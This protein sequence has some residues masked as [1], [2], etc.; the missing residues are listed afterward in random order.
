MYAYNHMVLA[1]GS[2]FHWRQQQCLSI[3]HIMRLCV[4]L[5]RQIYHHTSLLYVLDCFVHD[6]DSKLV[7]HVEF[8]CEGFGHG[9]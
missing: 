9:C 5:A 6:C 4:R 8:H 3:L 7:L 1:H 2:T